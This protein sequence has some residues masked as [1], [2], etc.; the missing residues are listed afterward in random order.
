M[1]TTESVGRATYLLTDQDRDDRTFA[2]ETWYPLAANTGEPLM[3]ELL[4]GVGFYRAAVAGGTPRSG[5]LPVVIVS[6]GHTGTRLVYSQL[7]EALAQRGYLVVSLDHPG[8]TMADVLLGAGVDE[9]TN[10]ELRVGDLTFLYESLIGRRPGFDHGCDIDTTRIHALGH[11]FGA[12]G[13]VEWAARGGAHGTLASLVALQPYLLPLTASSMRSVATPLL[14]VAGEKDQTTPVATN[15]AP[16]LEHLSSSLT[17][18]VVLEGVGHQGCSDVGLYIETAPSIEGVPDFVVDFLG[19]MSAD[20]TGTSGEPWRPVTAAHIEIV[21]TWLAN[22]GQ[23][24]PVIEVAHR[25]R[26]RVLT[27]S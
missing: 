7:C 6:H 11:S 21:A 14:I 9:P 23:R 25:H 15:V 26:G 20:T 24:E 12:Y 19:T 22:P 10:L 18:A 16:A 27:N 5:S 8:D 13:I 17:T 2:V 3:Y 1:T 4:P